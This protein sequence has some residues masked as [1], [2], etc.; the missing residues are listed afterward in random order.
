[1]SRG[2]PVMPFW[3]SISLTLDNQSDPASGTVGELALGRVVTSESLGLL[4]VVV[5]VP[6]SSLV[7]LGTR[8]GFSNEELQQ[9][10]WIDLLES[11][12][13]FSRSN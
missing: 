11:V 8:I 4:E 9:L 7:A 1:M 5:V 13:G 6:P 12:E 3:I 10:Q 2:V